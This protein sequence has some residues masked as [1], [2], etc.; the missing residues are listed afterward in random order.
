MDKTQGSAA[1]GCAPGRLASPKGAADAQA[2]GGEPIAQAL[3]EP[4][5]PTPSQAAVGA[6]LLESRQAQALPQ[7]P[8]HRL[9]GPRADVGLVAEPPRRC[10]QYLVRHPPILCLMVA[11]GLV[12]GGSVAVLVTLP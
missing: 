5:F 11:V 3:A 10:T 1:A 12:L 8:L 6:P 9:G 2:P 4:L 7:S